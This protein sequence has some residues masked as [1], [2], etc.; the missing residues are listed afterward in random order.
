MIRTLLALPLIAV[1]GAAAAAAAGADPPDF[2]SAAERFNDAGACLVHLEQVVADAR[3]GDFDAVEGPYAIGPSDMRAHTIR[4][5]GLGHRINE[6]R[7]VGAEL[8]AR[9]WV[10]R[11]DRRADGAYSIESLAGADWLE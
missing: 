1:A 6:Y 10:H 3:G 9:S 7:C 5:E 11:M 4:A 8:S 2:D